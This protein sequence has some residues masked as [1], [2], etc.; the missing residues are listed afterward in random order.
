MALGV[1]ARSADLFRNAARLNIDR[2]PSLFRDDDRSLV[3][4]GGGGKAG[5]GPVA[6]DG[7]T[8]ICW[9]GNCLLK[10][11]PI[12]DATL[13]ALMGLAN[14]PIFETGDKSAVC[15]LGKPWLWLWAAVLA[16]KGVSCGSRGE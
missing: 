4:L 8:S 10:I 11:C 6:V 2:C 1:V 15:K 5:G 13:I 7:V 12:G 9:A 14:S 3:E 16:W